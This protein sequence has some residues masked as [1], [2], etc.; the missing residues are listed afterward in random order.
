MHVILRYEIEKGLM[1]G[2]V[3]VSRYS[4]YHY[5]LYIANRAHICQF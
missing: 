3:K 5:I 1:S 4:K 2:S